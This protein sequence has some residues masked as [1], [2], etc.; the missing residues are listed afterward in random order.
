MAKISLVK[1]TKKFKDVYAA[2]DVNLVIQDQEFVVIVG[3][4]GCGKTT[5]LRMIAGLEKP[6]SGDIHIG[7]TRVNDLHPKDRD[8]SMV[9][10]NYALYPHMTVFQNMA[11]G[12]K[13]RKYPRSEIG[14]RVEEAATEMT[15]PQAKAYEA[16]L[17]SLARVIL[18]RNHFDG[19]ATRERYRRERAERALAY[20]HNWCGLL[21]G[22]IAALLIWIVLPW[23]G[24]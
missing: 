17:R 19:E 3:A 1:V 4:S 10:Q 14:R 24:K 23:V 8:V 21:M 15:S 7:D 20:A 13:L 11:F 5:T 6:T 18:E 16:L 22:V 12:L 9:F 2:K